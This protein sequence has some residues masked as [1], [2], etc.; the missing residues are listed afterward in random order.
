MMSLRPHHALCLL[1]FV[2]KNYSASYLEIMQRTIAE[3]SADPQKEIAVSGELD[4]I[5]GS[6]PHNDS[7]TCLKAE[8]VRE[9]TAGVLRHS[10][11]SYGEVMTWETLRRKIIDGVLAGGADDKFRE[12]CG[13]CSYYEQCRGAAEKVRA[14]S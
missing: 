14:K 12:T 4:T 10:G 5:C 3:L 6:C 13:N 8:N 2:P 1:C 11:I 9:I 7:G